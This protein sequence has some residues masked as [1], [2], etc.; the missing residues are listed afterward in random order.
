MADDRGNIPDSEPLKVTIDPPTAPEVHSRLNDERLKIKNRTALII[1]E[2]ASHTLILGLALGSL[3]LVHLILETLLGNEARFFDSV[4]VRW[5]IDVAD[6]LVIGKFLWQ[7][8]KDFRR[9]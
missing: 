3:W 7:V 1:L 6:L 9:G 5:I 4:P 8:I 2:L